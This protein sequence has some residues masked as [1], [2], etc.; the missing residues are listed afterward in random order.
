[1]AEWA[2]AYEKGGGDGSHKTRK[3]GDRG[4]RQ[5]GGGDFY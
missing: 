5:G 1:M 4:A 3:F 2:A